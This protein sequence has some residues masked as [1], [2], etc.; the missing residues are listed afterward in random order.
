MLKRL[1]YV[2]MMLLML[3]LPVCAANA[4]ENASSV[5]AIQQTGTCKGVVIDSTGEG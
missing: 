5:E 2:S 3:A 4:S 1:Q